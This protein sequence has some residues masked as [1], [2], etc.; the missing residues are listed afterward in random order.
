LLAIS[1]YFTD[2][3]AFNICIEES[4]IPSIARQLILL[5]ERCGTINLGCNLPPDLDVGVPIGGICISKELSIHSVRLAPYSFLGTVQMLP[6][7]NLKPLITVYPLKEVVK[8]FELIK[9]V[10]A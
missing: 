7:L 9:R 2:V 4:G 6:K 5:A 3:K 1:N 8:A 10:K